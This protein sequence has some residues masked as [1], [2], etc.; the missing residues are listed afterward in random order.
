MA[1]NSIY[2]PLV[3]WLVSEM[4]VSHLAPMDHSIGYVGTLNDY[5]NDEM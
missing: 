4:G 1:D 2:T 5:A 3:Y